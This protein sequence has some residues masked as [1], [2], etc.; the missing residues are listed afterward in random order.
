MERSVVETRMGIDFPLDTQWDMNWEV[1][2][3]EKCLRRW[4]IP[5]PQILQKEP[6]NTMQGANGDETYNKGYEKQPQTRVPEV[7]V[8]GL[9]LVSHRL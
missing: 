7:G 3:R 4:S 1:G 5:S 9:G 8:R 6:Q 2:W